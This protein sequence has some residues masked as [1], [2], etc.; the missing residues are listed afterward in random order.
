[1]VSFVARSQ[2]HIDPLD[3]MRGIMS[4]ITAKQYTVLVRGSIATTIEIPESQTWAFK[5]GHRAACEHRPVE[6][7]GPLPTNY[8]ICGAGYLC[9]KWQF[10]QLASLLDGSAL[11]SYAE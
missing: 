8:A 7:G 4:E 2:R 1:M 10:R 11:K 9:E 3:D 6:C 5:A